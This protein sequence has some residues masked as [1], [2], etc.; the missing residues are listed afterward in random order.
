MQ[1]DY[2]DFIT[3]TLDEHGIDYREFGK[4]IS[5]K[6]VGV[7]C[8]ACGDE[9]FHMGVMTDKLNCTCWKCKTSMSFAQYMTEATGLP[10]STFF[11]TKQQ[12]KVRDYE[13][14]IK[15]LEESRKRAYIRECTEGFTPVEVSLPPG[16]E[17][18]TMDFQSDLLD[19]WLERRRVLKSTVV[20]KYC[21]YCGFG[22]FAQRILVPVLYERVMVGYVCLDLTGKSS[23]KALN[24]GNTALGNYLYGIDDISFGG[25]III[26]EGILDSWTVF[27]VASLGTN[28]TDRQMKLIK[29]KH[30][31]LLVVLWDGDAYLKSRA[32][33]KL[34]TVADRVVYV[35]LP[36]N[37]DPDSFGRD[38]CLQSIKK[39]ISEIY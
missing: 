31:N 9:S 16:C 35:R 33:L 19:S 20:S 32:R 27:G 2:R 7:P 11:L 34:G 24:S 28:L 29:S 18:I 6:A 10:I 5:Q 37:D 26:T 30:P 3:N 13:S 4:N 14:V 38:R 12:G 8:I 36:L 22:K 23:S 21:Y 1:D 25:T 17:K 15:K 39:K